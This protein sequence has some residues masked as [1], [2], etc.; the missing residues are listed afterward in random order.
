MLDRAV[1][2]QPGRLARHLTTQIGRKSKLLTE[3]SMC[4]FFLHQVARIERMER[5]EC[6]THGVLAWYR[7]YTTRRASVV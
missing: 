2:P 1:H 3:H 7:A 5:M 6:I 4:I